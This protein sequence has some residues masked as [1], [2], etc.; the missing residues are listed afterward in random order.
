MRID[1]SFTFHFCGGLIAAASRLVPAHQRFDWRREWKAEL[2]HRKAA[3]E[4]RDSFT[5]A[6]RLDLI[7]RCLGA[8]RHAVWLRKQE[9]SLAMI[10]QDI[11]YAVRGLRKRPSFTLITVITLALGV[12]AN[13]AIFSLV[14]GVLLE[15][16]PYPDSAE[17]IR[18]YDTHLERGVTAG[19][20]S[21]ANFYDW[22]DQ[23]DV[24]TDIAGFT[25][26][27]A[28]LTEVRP[29][30]A[31]RA[32][33]VS[34]QMFRV[35][36]VMPARGRPFSREEEQPGRDRVVIVSHG[37]WQSYLG[38]DPR[39]VSRTLSLNGDAYQV[40]GVMPPGFQFPN[41]ET[42]LWLPLSFDF[43]VPS[44]RGAHFVYVIGR[45]RPGTTL[46][47]AQAGMSSLAS[48]LESAYPDMNAGWS[49]RL[50]TLHDS[51]V[52]GVRTRLLV[53]F[54]AVGLVLLITCVN[55][56]NLLLV[57]AISRSRE[58][59]LRAAVG[60]GRARLIRQV[61]SESVVLAAL[62]G[63][64]AL[65]LAYGALEGLLALD[66]G[67]LPRLD[68]VQID[69]LAFA[70]AFG[71][72]LVVGALVGLLPAV[73]AARTE[74]FD[75]LRA[76]GRD[77]ALDFSKTRLRSGLVVAEIALALV[78]T[79]A[80]GLLTLTYSRLLGVESGFKSEGVLAFS[81][82]LPGVRYPEEADKHRFFSSLVE[83]T[84]NIPGVVSAGAVTQLPLNRWAIN[85]GFAI[86]GAPDPGASEGPEGDFRVVTGH[87]FETL[88][89]PL[90]RGRAFSE[91]D[92]RDSPR[93]ILINQSLAQR[94]FPDRDPLGERLIVSYGD[95]QPAEIIG[96][97]A[98]VKQ[99][100]LDVPV[101]PGYYFPL[102]Q[103]GWS[104]MFV[105][106]RTH[107]EPTAFMRVVR[108]EVAG[109]DPEL[110]VT[111]IHTLRERVTS[112]VASPR[113][114]MML[115]S[116]FAALALLLA[117]VGVYGVMSYLVTQRTREIG[118]RLALGA[119]T[120]AVRRSLSMQGLKLAG[121]GVG[122]GLLAALGLTRLMSNL[123]FG[124][125]V[126]D[127]GIFMAAAL[128]LGT[129]TWLGSYVPA[130]RAS[131]V[132]PTEALRAE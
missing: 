58:M 70:F 33:N 1:R 119:S 131:G 52:G 23:Q 39:A 132:D 107:L 110:S 47:Q 14:K 91:T 32:A 50:T 18:L 118:V 71:L 6:Q 114:N 84:A 57:R 3:L 56:I 15:P 26:G 102:S 31:V 25:V 104:S 99:R 55:V 49:V 106:L 9:W 22:R 68:N 43:D 94:Y 122:L 75:A 82:S 8:V 77:S 34:S 120:A 28:T 98:D 37:F 51:L 126:T 72:S 109:L 20:S 86:D 53:L 45:L 4:R 96:I 69:W 46:R 36:G 93:V 111:D 74:L 30:E 35:L 127:P 11:R 66:P 83:R 124:V 128:I 73:R 60:A 125:S 38:S 80:A 78:L 24:F 54:G 2:W 61:V 97:V 115:M 19:T 76:G 63:T 10:G 129:A 100:A 89:I 85:F 121:L 105:V 21:P 65:A 88:G 44:S 16:L 48:R 5:V 113:F 103:V 90:L 95:G 17:L 7:L 13:T 59:A 108:D 112:S 81:V 92:T 27:S 40:V 12:G 64:L 79:T 41:N 67:R 42:Q 117:A 101:R 130:V 116:A 29:P 62:S 87:Y 123:L